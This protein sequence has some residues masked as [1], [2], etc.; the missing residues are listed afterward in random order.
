MQQNQILFINAC[1]REAS[2]TRQLAA[3]V[4]GKLRGNIAEL[5]LAAENISPLNA[6]SL[7]YRE[8]AVEKADFSDSMFRYAKQFAQA[9][10]IVIA[11]PYWDL[12]FPAIL[13]EYF[14]QVS[15]CGVTF[16]Y[17]QDGRVIGQCRAKTV[18]YV[19]T[20]GAPGL[21]DDFG[22]GYVKALCSIYYGI[23]ETVLFQASG[24]DLFGADTEALL[25]NARI[26]ID[27]YFEQKSL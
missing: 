3:Y 11:A 19:T 7:L 8:T 5:D 20:V 4:L 12:S 1:V 13:K 23:P 14:E 27:R 15:V 2:R 18:Y 10:E 17:S 16:R 26:D 22:Y 9:D 24:L 25:Q 21:P 6:A